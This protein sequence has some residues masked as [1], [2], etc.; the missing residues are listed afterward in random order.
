MVLCLG[1]FLAV[2]TPAAP[3][4]VALLTGDGQSAAAIGAMTG[5]KARVFKPDP[6]AHA[7]YRDLYALYSVLHDAFGK[8][9]W[10]GS[11]HAVMKQLIDLRHHARA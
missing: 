11:L 8:A 4:K 1:L 7:V 3:V 10:Q 9:N 5:L 6:A 2:A